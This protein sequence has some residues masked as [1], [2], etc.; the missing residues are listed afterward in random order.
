MTHL[1]STVLL[2]RS[3]VCSPPVKARQSSRTLESNQAFS[4]PIGSRSVWRIHINLLSTRKSRNF[5]PPGFLCPLVSL[6]NE[7]FIFFSFWQPEKLV[8]WGHVMLNSDRE[9]LIPYHYC[10]EHKDRVPDAAN[11]EVHWHL[12]SNQITRNRRGTIP[13]RS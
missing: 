13:A 5:Y 3:E 11:P 12:P 8:Y 1:A 4:P 9:S 2:P 7:L 10:Y 6:L